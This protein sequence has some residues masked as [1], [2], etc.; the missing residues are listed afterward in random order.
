VCGISNIRCWL[1][2]SGYAHHD[3]NVTALQSVTC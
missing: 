3:L 1:N 2:I